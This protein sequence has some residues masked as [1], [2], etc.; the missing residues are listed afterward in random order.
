ML[1]TTRAAIAIKIALS[2]LF[3]MP[4]HAQEMFTGRDFME[5]EEVS[6]HS[7][8]HTSVIMAMFIGTQTRKEIV[9]CIGEWYGPDAGMQAQRNAEIIA[10]IAEHDTYH[11]SSV[12]L[13]LIHNEC[14]RF[15]SAE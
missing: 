14:G 11:P 13:S 10:L 6:Q 2:T 15:P 1:R 5:W 3:C 9:T 8:I 7:Y 4:S 12:I